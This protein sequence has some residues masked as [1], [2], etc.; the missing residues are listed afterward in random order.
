MRES[1]RGCGSWEGEGGRE[2]GGVS[3]G[4]ELWVVLAGEKA[5][6]GAM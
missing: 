3:N 5:G 1:R 6:G 4:F 2:T